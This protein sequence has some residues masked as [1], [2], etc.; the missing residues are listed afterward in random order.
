[1][2]EIVEDLFMQDCDS[3]F[4]SFYICQGNIK[5]GIKAGKIDLAWLPV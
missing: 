3:T 5:S 4:W 1:M 2:A